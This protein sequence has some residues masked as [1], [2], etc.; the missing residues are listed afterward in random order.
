MTVIASSLRVAA[1]QERLPFRAGRSSRRRRR[2]PQVA[3]PPSIRKAGKGA[4]LRTG[5]RF[6][7]LCPFP[8]FVRRSPCAFRTDTP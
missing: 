8:A 5:P 3:S 2:E 6:G 7:P 4:A 1:K